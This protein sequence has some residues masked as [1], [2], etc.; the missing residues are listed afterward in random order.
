MKKK[1]ECQ[2]TTNMATYLQLLGSSRDNKQIP[3][4][5]NNNL[6]RYIKIYERI[7]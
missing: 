5:T 4:S 2:K 6:Y 1:A 3:T 7:T